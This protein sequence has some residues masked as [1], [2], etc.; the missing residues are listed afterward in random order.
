MSPFPTRI[1]RKPKRRSTGVVAG[2]MTRLPANTASTS[3][4]ER[5]GSIPKPTWNMS[6]SRNGTALIAIR[7][8][9]PS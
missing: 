6:G 8:S 5:N 3:S 9:E 1:V 7:K 4:P 2:F